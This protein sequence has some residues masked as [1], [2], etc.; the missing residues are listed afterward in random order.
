MTQSRFITADQ[1]AEVFA[2]CTFRLSDMKVI[3]PDGTAVNRARFNILFGGLTFAMDTANER[4]TRVA[5][6]AFTD[7]HAFRPPIFYK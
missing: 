5:W 3:L 2:G 7:N 6:R 4:T 1:L